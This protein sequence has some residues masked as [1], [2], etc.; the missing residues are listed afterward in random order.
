M[1][2][3]FGRI[4]PRELQPNRLDETAAA[5][6][7]SAALLFTSWCLS[8]VNLY[9]AT[10]ASLWCALYF[11]GL[12][13]N[14]VLKMIKNCQSSMWD[15]KNCPIASYRLP[16]K[17][18]NNQNI[19]NQWCSV[20]SW[21]QLADNRCCRWAMLATEM[22]TLT[23]TIHKHNSTVYCLCTSK[24][25]QLSHSFANNNNDRL[26]AFDPGQPG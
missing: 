12:T 19:Q 11:I 10:T 15:H 4:I 8:T 17:V 26:T 6:L 3:T 23:I 7:A 22:H 13:I 20:N 14:K 2:K 1:S 9:N 18:P 16:W 21:W 25:K 5:T 24:F